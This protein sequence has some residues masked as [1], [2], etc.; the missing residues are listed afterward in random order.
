MNAIIYLIVFIFGLVIGSFLNALIYR[1]K[2]KKS[3][4]HGRSICPNC[5]KKLKF[6]DLLPIF[7][8][9]LLHGRCRYCHR[10][11][12]W[13]YPLVEMGTGIVFVLVF[14]YQIISAGHLSVISILPLAFYLF[15]AS[16][17][18]V[19]FVYD[20]QNYLIPDKVVLS[21]IIFAILYWIAATIF[22]LLRYKEI[23]YRLYPHTWPLIYNP[24]LIFYG[25]LLGG[26]FFF[27]N[28]SHFTR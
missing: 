14:Y 3:I 28:C 15:I 5:K 25:A 24:W 20:L 21:N 8:F 10:K 22:Y 27:I 6:W 12:S 26:G 11:I 16:G 2:N 1:I 17:L 18:I 19:I 9:I 4:W 13:Q 7:S 23:Y